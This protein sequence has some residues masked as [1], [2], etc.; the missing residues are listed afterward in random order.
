MIPLGAPI[1]FWG[2]GYIDEN[3]GTLM[4]FYISMN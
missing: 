1:W 2:F 3:Y 4:E